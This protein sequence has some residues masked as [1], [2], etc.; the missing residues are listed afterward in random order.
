MHKPK[1]QPDRLPPATGSAALVGCIDECHI[2][3]AGIELYARQ[4]KSILALG[5][6]ICLQA[7]IERLKQIVGVVPPNDQVERLPPTETQTEETKP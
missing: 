2:W 1:T 5:R 3:L 7:E 4:G 6:I